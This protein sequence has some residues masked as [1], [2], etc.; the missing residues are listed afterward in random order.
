[1]SGLYHSNTLF[2][3]VPALGAIS[4]PNNGTAKLM[5]IG[6]EHPGFELMEGTNR[7]GRDPNQNQH[8]ILSSHVSRCHCEVIL[9]QGQ[10]KICDLNS[11]N[12]T[13]VNGQRVTEQTINPGDKIGVSRRITFAVVM[14]SELEKPIGKV[15]NLEQRP[16]VPAFRHA[17]APKVIPASP[18]VQVLPE[19]LPLSA[20]ENAVENEQQLKQMEQQRN[21]LAILY[22]LTLRCLLAADS[23]EAEKLILNVLERLIPLDTGFILYHAQDVWQAVICPHAKVRPTDSVLQSA[24]HLAIQQKTATIVASDELK[25]LGMGFNSAMLAPMMINEHF[26]GVVG[27]MT[28]AAKDYHGE[29]LEILIQLANISAAALIG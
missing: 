7:I 24:Y 20:E 9:T 11:H 26:S 4:S 6:F 23:K 25:S 17:M 5:P 19:A 13:Y 27:V 18:P 16:P 3:A 29:L 28:E 21:I 8:V 12:G 10:M 22:Q 14:D 2:G 1:M 15:V